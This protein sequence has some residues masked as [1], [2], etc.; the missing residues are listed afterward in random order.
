MRDGLYKNLPL[1]RPWQAALRSCTLDAER[2]TIAREKVERAIGQDLQRE[3]QAPF[4]RAFR[5]EADR[6]ESLLPGFSAFGEV[7]SRDLGGQNTPLQNEIIAQA[8]HLEG[9]GLKGAG[10]A[11]AAVLSAVT[12]RKQRCGRQMEQT[13]LT[14][15]SDSDAKATISAVRNAISGA[16]IAPLVEAFIAGCPL[17]L[18]PARHP[19]DLDEEISRTSHDSD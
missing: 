18:P 1:P 5:E 19:I 16:K 2:G 11:T 4:M 10:L 7:T 14:S 15:G 17:D 9:A 12:E 3:V 13:A 6:A 8:R